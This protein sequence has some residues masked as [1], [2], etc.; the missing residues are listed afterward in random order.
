M[1]GWM[2]GWGGGGGGLLQ[3]SAAGLD[4]SPQPRDGGGVGSVPPSSTVSGYLNS[5]QLSLLRPR[6]KRAGLGG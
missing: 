5:L 2:W 4:E 1:W 6:L 3:A